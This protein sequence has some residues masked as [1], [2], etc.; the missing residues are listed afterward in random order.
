MPC[1]CYIS[2]WKTQ[3]ICMIRPSFCWELAWSKTST[4]LT[5][6]GI[7]LFTWWW[8]RSIGYCHQEV[9]KSRPTMTTGSY[10][11]WNFCSRTTATPTSSTPAE[12]MP[13][14]NCCLCL[15]LSS[16]TIQQGSHWRRCQCV[17]CSKQTLTC[18]TE[19]W[20]CSSAMVQCPMPQLVPAEH[21]LWCW[22]KACWTL[23][24]WSFT[25]LRRDFSSARNWCVHVVPTQATPT[26]PT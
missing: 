3:C 22:C 4:Q 21:H 5:C 13:C 11:P 1:I 16:V 6:M 24:P 25:A 10:R 9:Q 18:C 20:R 19:L 15:T 23:T 8:H 14:T 2:M 7:Q 12:S 26:R 17:K